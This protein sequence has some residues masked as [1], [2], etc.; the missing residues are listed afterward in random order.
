MT[1]LA[2]EGTETLG[3]EEFSARRSA[4]L[5][6]FDDEIRPIVE[7]SLLN[8][9]KRD[10]YADIVQG[11]GVL[12][13]EIFNHQ[14]PTGHP[15]AMIDTFLRELAESLAKTSEPSTP[16][17][18]AEIDRV[19][20]WVGVYSVNSAT[21]FAGR[22]QGG[23]EKTWITMEDD[24]VR[25]IHAVVDQVTVPI[26]G[27]FEVGG[28]QMHFPGEPVGSPEHWINCR[29]IL[30][31]TGGIQMGNKGAKF[32]LATDE[33]VDEGLSDEDQGD[34]LID[35][36]MAETPWH[37]V[38]T[39]EGNETGD[40]RKIGKD[41]LSFPEPAHMPAPLMY[42]EYTDGVP[43]G[44][45]VRVGRIDEMWRHE[46]G[47]IRARGAF[48]LNVMEAHK[49]IDGIMFGGGAGVSVDLDSTEFELEWPEGSEEMDLDEMLEVRPVEVITAAR[50]RGATMVGFG[51]FIEGYIALGPDFDD[52]GGAESE[53]AD[54]PKMVSRDTDAEGMTHTVWED[55][56][57]TWEA[58]D[59]DVLVKMFDFLQSDEEKTAAQYDEHA[60]LVASAFAPGT[61]DGPG[62]LTNPRA[63]QRLRSYWVHGEGAAKI[64]W[65]A[66]GDFNRCR[67]QLAKYVNPAFLAGTCANLHKEALKIWPST[68][69][70]ILGDA[71]ND[72]ISRIALVASAALEEVTPAHFFAD[73]EFTELTPLTIDEDGHIFGHL[74]QWGVCH[75]AIHERCVMAPHSPT[76]YSYYANGV[77]M[78]DDGPVNTGRLMMWT[79]HAG[80]L[81]AAHKASRHYDDTGH[82]VADLAVGEDAIGI[83][84]S[85]KVRDS[86]SDEDIR[87]LRASAVSGDWRDVR[88]TSTSITDEM[89]GLIAVNA[90]GFPMPRAKFGMVGDKQVS[91]LASA[92]IVM[93]R[94]VEEVESALGRQHALT[95]EELLMISRSVADEIEYR[96]Q[97][98][99]RLAAAR[100]P[101]LISAAEA[102]RAERLVAART[103]E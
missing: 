56:S 96:G 58:D 79:G 14:S 53:V 101:E 35:D 99:E 10:W 61:H 67:L 25:S 5:N 65:G 68:H 98:A 21:F 84:F 19:V 22:D 26:L 90:G 39:T 85:G 3:L 62:W 2:Y 59:L 50:L 47:E 20:R 49:A 60:A 43:H 51:A 33:D 27:T 95:A 73:P 71:K 100:D 102:R 80:S 4:R 38:L 69:A 8:W 83:W 40:K 82:A 31:V 44:R 1:T 24:K 15:G 89:I 57:Q 93:P 97:K 46:S 37:G 11:A 92:G 16:P 87:V 32:A 48:N 17:T 52:E 7:A 76:D 63:T 55:G 103:L 18:E 66:P 86:A 74:A 30:A 94:K 88:M 77:T 29:C 81:L 6:N 34:D 23:L 41:S 78:T 13:L 64:K 45:S 36:L 72:A 75:L 42:Q 12:W 9:G 70:K 28:V 91:L 54:A